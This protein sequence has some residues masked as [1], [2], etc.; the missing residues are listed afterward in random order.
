MS[1]DKVLIELGIALR[2]AREEAGLTIQQL[3]DRAHV[4]IPSIS[5][6]ERGHRLNPTYATIKTLATALNLKVALSVHPAL[7][8]PTDGLP[9]DC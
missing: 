5:E 9:T 6:I 7:R 2:A 4:S 3:A 1:N 8:E